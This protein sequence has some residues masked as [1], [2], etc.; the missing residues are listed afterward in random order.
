MK[1]ISSGYSTLCGCICLVSLLPISHLLGQAVKDGAGLGVVIIAAKDGPTRFLDSQGKILPTG[2]TAIGAALPEGNVAQAGVGGKIVLLLSNGTVTTLESQTKLKIREFSQEP[3]D[4]AGRKISDLKTEPSKS[5]VKLDLDWG[6]IVVTTK[7]LDR[8]SSL[9]IQSPSGTAGIRG[10]QFRL[11]ENLGSGTKLDVTESTVTFTPKGGGESVAVG[12]GKGL[13]ISSAGVVTPR[14]ISP[15]AAKSI[16]ATNAE[17]IQVTDDVLLSV[18]SEAMGDALMIEDKGLREDDG[19]DPQ[20]EGEPTD[21][22]EGNNKDNP[23]NEKVSS[24]ESTSERTP[25]AIHAAGQPSVDMGQVLENNPAAKQVR[26]LGKA[27]ELSFKMASMG[28][29]DDKAQMFYS[30]STSTQNAL[31]AA[32]KETV[33]RLLGLPS[34]KE[35]DIWSFLNY[36]TE[37]RVRL[38][39]LSD[40]QMLLG[41][42]R[43]GYE[44]SSLAVILSDENL[45]A[46]NPSSAPIDVPEIGTDSNVLKLSETLKESGN[47]AI[48]NELLQLGGGELT[49]ELERVGAVANLLLTDFTVPGEIEESVLLSGNEVLSNPFYREVSSVYGYLEDDLLVAGEA[50]FLGG[51]NV[52]MPPGAY[53]V[54]GGVGSTTDLFVFSA[55]EKLK[56]RDEVS[57]AEFGRGEHPRVVLMSGGSLE[58]TKGVTLDAATNDLVLSVRRDVLLQYATLKGNREVTIRSLR[59]LTLRDSE[60]DASGI[61][62]LKATQN[63]YVDGLNF[64]RDIPRIVMEASTIRLVNIDFPGSSIVNLN[65]LKGPIDGRYPNFGTD[66]PLVQQ[67]GRVNFLQNIKSGGNL[68]HDRSTFDQFGG[69]IKI[70]KLP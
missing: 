68:M 18:L 40:D 31:L 53:R 17:S 42:I 67:L 5:S 4:A 15:L 6:S 11:A 54:A 65:S 37:T 19:A 34:G 24:D 57:F 38:L 14:A 13:D 49:P 50:S 33:N 64:S 35:L 26:K 39:A 3:F 27:N 25:A 69:N 66:I 30:F 10:T 60:L 32:G 52:D 1:I 61:A 51:R 46:S 21:Q 63:L 7:K 44:E 28:L 12:P 29:S 59:D 8:A 9:Q 20:D 36:S 47:I 58:A 16:T 55:S 62:T 22:N 2:K 43:K 41:L 70:G 48:L 45:Q 56:I 23:T